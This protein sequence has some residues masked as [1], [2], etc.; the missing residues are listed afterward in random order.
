MRQEDMSIRSIGLTLFV[1]FST[2]CSEAY[3]PIPE[4]V[5]PPPPKLALPDCRPG[6]PVDQQ[7]GFALIVDILRRNGDIER[8]NAFYGDIRA[9]V[10][11]RLTQDDPSA[12]ARLK[13]ALDQFFS[14][15]EIE[16]N[17]TCSFFSHQEV[18]AEVEAWD[19]WSQ[20]KKMR[21]IH[22]HIL[23]FMVTSREQKLTV[24]GAR[25]ALLVRVSNATGMR[26]Y[27]PT[28]G[29]VYRQS[30]A[31]ADAAVDST[32]S[33]LQDLAL[34]RVFMHGPKEDEIIE[35]LLAPELAGVSNED[36]GRFLAFAETRE[37]RA[38]YEA[39]RESFGYGLNDWYPRLG[40]L[41]KTGV[42]PADAA[43]DPEAAAKML[44][45]AR[46]LFD[47][48]GTR[49]VVAEART[50]LLKAERLDPKNAEIQAL[51]G[52]VALSTMSSGMP[53]P[54]GEI[55]GRFDKMHPA[56][57]ERYKEAETYLHRA[58]ELDPKNAEAQLALGRIHFWLSQ[59][60]EAARQF[61]LVRR[62]NP[63]T[64][65]LKMAEADAAYA[66]GQYAKAERGYRQI[67]A[68]PEERAY[69]HHFA[70]GHLSLALTKQGKEKEFRAAAQQQLLRDKKL[71]DF[72]MSY[73]DRL[74][75]SD[76]T[77]EEVAALIEPVP[78]QWLWEEKRRL[79]VRLQLLRASKAD[80]AARGNAIRAAFSIAEE[81]M[82]VVDAT[83]IARGRPDLVPGVIRESGNADFFADYLL[84]CSFRRRD[85]AFIDA[86][87]PFVKDIDRPNA[88][89]NGERPLCVASQVMPSSI[90]ET[91][92]KAKADPSIRCANGKTVREDLKERSTRIGVSES[93]NA[94]ARTLLGILDKYDRGG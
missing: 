50:L 64:P 52:R 67:L 68:D 88:S 2:G 65:G 85:Q 32:S 14:G 83:C 80:A 29:L 11:M 48:I 5:R 93:F 73:A 53:L 36:L 91:M 51:L 71:W 43:W 86:V 66:S 13:P 46:R 62:L 47:G 30:L 34:K 84:T 42:K 18:Q 92:L 56:F 7:G 20:D 17:A 61:A 89:F 39:L 1:L 19:T 31:V 24:D 21:D 74:L 78:D 79:L 90:F 82:E 27:V 38:Y 9:M 16:K 8:A 40:A 70:L 33:E 75:S 57:P 72:R 87:V 94:D 3:S 58:I 45:E 25:R 4:G 41:L 60:E 28:L 22:A 63:K 23:S 49:V 76:G 77:V 12:P 69:A 37:G 59:D 10:E 55:R 26:D 54:D 44:A 81:P 15:K 6:Y 35:R